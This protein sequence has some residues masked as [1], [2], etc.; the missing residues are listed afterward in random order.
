MTDLQLLH[1]ADGG[2]LCL[3]GG[4]L[5]LDRT[6]S[7][8]A[9]LSL[10]GGNDDDDATPAATRRSWWGNA[11][12]LDEARRVRSRTQYALRSLR[13]AS[14]N[15]PALEAAARAD[16]GWMREVLGAE[17]TVSASLPTTHRVRIEIAIAIDAERYEA[18]FEAPWPLGARSP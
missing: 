4:Q 1:S 12:E 17:V 11:M 2:E 6:P 3:S 5:L 7:T 15:L 9:Y 16:L 13:R 8:A 18:R 10:F 14:G